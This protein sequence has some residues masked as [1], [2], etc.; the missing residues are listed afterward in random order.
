MKT[1]FGV[2]R[3][4]RKII[5]FHTPGH[6][7]K[8]ARITTK[9][10]TTELAYSDNLLNA[11]GIIKNLEDKVCKVYEGKKAF[12]STN[13]ATNS[14]I[15]AIYATRHRGSFLIIGE[16]HK[17]IYNAVRI[18]RAKAY[19]IEKLPSKDEELSADISTVIATSPDYFGN[20]MSLDKLATFAKERKLLLIID[21]SH[22][23]H[24]AFSSK[25]PTSPSKYGDLVVYSL[26]KTLA[27][28]TGGA[29]LICNNASLIEHCSLARKMFHSTSPSYMTLA[30]IDKVFMSN[31]ATL[32]KKYDKVLCAIEKFKKRN[33]GVFRC[34]SN[35]D[36]SRLIIESDFDGERVNAELMKNSIAMEMHYKNSV[37]AIV[38][39]YN[40]KRLKKL[41]RTL[42]KVSKMDLS[43]FIDKTM[44][45]AE[46]AIRIVSYDCDYEMVPLEYAKG[47]KAFLEIGLYPPGVPIIRAG[48]IF[49]SET[50]CTI[51]KNINNCF[52]LENGMVAVILYNDGGKR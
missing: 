47:K 16:G 20:V 37:V 36:F 13:G 31:Q 22:A 26:H 50:I 48:E 19:Y 24:Y 34:K 35:D 10:D 9:L 8:L 51:K 33:L 32:E 5:S 41:A 44:P 17:S 49:D 11:T 14:I 25:F 12:L 45:R 52:G 15:T 38:T 3:K 1:L 4:N 30:S 40:Y 7:N 42:K 46:D 28:A 39:P 18:A 2:L 6:N 29:V 21:A 27:V 23:A 43:K